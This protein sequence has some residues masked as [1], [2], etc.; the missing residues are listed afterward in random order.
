MQFTGK[1]YVGYGIFLIVCGVAGFLSNPE[2]AKTALITGSFFGSLAIIV[3]VLLKK[4]F[5]WAR[6][7]AL[8]LTLLLIAAFSWRSFVS[9]QDVARGD[10]KLFAA[11][12]ISSML[13]ASLISL[14]QLVSH[15]KNPAPLVTPK[16]K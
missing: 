3:G 1:W 12:L 16:G 11:I 4:E 10:P 2:A 13:V 8:G 14:G 5:G 9:W 7:P 15:W 6:I